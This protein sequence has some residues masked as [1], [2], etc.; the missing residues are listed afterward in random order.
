MQPADASVVQHECTLRIEEMFDEQGDSMYGGEDVTQLQH[1]LQA[2]LLAEQQQAGDA[3]I[4]A[5]LLHDVGHLLHEL[6]D[7]APLQGIDDRHEDLAAAWLERH[8]PP[9]VVQPV[10][11]HVE[12]KRYLC[13]TEPGY[14]DALSLPSKQSLEL[15]GGIM[16]DE[17]CESFRQGEHFEA[18][19]RLRRWDDEAKVAN[20][21][22]PPVKHFLPYVDRVATPAS[23]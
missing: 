14:W 11:L 16:T 15:Q 20:L 10:K 23:A 17:E 18:A 12:S 13:A 1:A 2:A 3:L 8:F 7:D 4:A 19:I 5:A 6:P 21:E 9:A 22:T